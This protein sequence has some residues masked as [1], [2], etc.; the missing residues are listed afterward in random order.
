LSQKKPDPERPLELVPRFLRGGYD[1]ESVNLRRTWVE[2]RAKFEAPLIGAHALT[3]SSMRGNIENPI[4]TAQIPLGIAGPLLIDGT[5]A[6]GIFYVPMATTEGALVRSYE[7][8]MATLTRAGGVKTRV[9]I[10]ENRVSPVFLF[11]DIAAAA[12][13]AATL[14]DKFE[15]IRVEA[16]SSTRHGKLLRLE[17]HPI[18]RQVIVCFCFSTGDAH[19]MNMIV[20]ATDRAC[21]WI[22]ANSQARRYHLFGGLESE[23]RPTALL[24][25]GGKG[26]K[27]TA[28]ATISSKLLRKYLH[29]SPAEMTELWHHGVL[30]NIQAGSLGHGGHLANGV[31]AIFIACGQDVANVANAAVGITDFEITDQ[32]DLYVSVTMAS[33][34]VATV[35][36]G[37]GLG[38]GRE[39]LGLLG[40]EGTGKARKFAE[41]VA[42]TLL[43]GEISFAAAVASGEFVSAHESYGRNRPGKSP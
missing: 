39:C 23:K 5:D 6:R 25:P 8:G 10:D 34:T 33:L 32:E 12:D 19:G 17:C 4:G 22:V 31:A 16:E 30:G 43:A 35:G 36:G 14:D 1:P 7:R 28:G 18:A 27:V 20:Q 11:D 15:S 40:C 9:L 26:K 38:T 3:D 2:E 21:G 41:I 29:T 37:T 13:F 24:L 42:A